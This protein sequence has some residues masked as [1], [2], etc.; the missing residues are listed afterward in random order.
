MGRPACPLPFTGPQP[1][2]GTQE[3]GTWAGRL[4][5]LRG[6]ASSRGAN[7]QG[8]GINSPSPTHLLLEAALELR[9]SPLIIG[10]PE[11]SHPFILS[12]LQADWGLWHRP[13]PVMEGRRHTSQAQGSDGGQLERRSHPPLPPSL[14]TLPT[15]SKVGK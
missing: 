8:A 11:A 13:H 7:I 15:W 12:L 3:E 2:D 14:L 10:R 5:L 4:D 9:L 6:K 1:E